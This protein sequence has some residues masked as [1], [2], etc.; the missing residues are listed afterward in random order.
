MVSVVHIILLFTAHVVSLR[1]PSVCA[2]LCEDD[3]Q[4]IWACILE[5]ILQVCWECVFESYP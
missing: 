3:V 2:Q 4:P 5:Q 1:N